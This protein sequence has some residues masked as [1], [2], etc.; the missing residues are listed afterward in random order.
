[1]LARGGEIRAA[2]L[3]DADLNQLPVAFV[4][5][6]SQRASILR[7]GG[8][9]EPVLKPH[10]TALCGDV[11]IDAVP[12]ANFGTGRRQGDGLSEVALVGAVA[13]D[14]SVALE[15]AGSAGGFG[16]RRRRENRGEEDEGD[17]RDTESRGR[18]EQD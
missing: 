2:V 9:K 15:Q 7:V 17:R 18:E 4:A 10:L 6:G 14:G 3:S 1:M 16:L 5:T 12:L 8:E 11:A 13:Q